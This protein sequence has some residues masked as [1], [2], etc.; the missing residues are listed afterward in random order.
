MESH[1]R[2]SIK[3]GARSTLLAAGTT[4]A[5]QLLA[6]ASTALEFGDKLLQ[7]K[8]QK[9]LKKPHLDWARPIR[10][11]RTY[12]FERTLP[13]PVA[14]RLRSSALQVQILY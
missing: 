13:D 2:C 11:E 8:L 7:Q 5:P 4:A 14:D 10:R 1:S 3:T 9:N 12:L 6:A